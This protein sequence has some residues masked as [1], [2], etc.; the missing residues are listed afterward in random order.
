MNLFK[1]TKFFRKFGF[2]GFFCWVLYFQTLEATEIIGSAEVNENFVEIVDV[3]YRGSLLNSEETFFTQGANY[4]LSTEELQKFDYSDP[5][6]VLQSVPGVYIQEEDGFGLRPNIGM[7]GTSPHRSKKVTLM[8]DGVLITPAPYSSPAAYFFPNMMKIHSVEIFKGFSSVKFGPHTLGGAINFVTNPIPDEDESLQEI[9]VSLGRVKKYR[10]STGWGGKNWGY[11]LESYRMESDGFKSLPDGGDTGFEKNDIL[12]K[13]EYK[14]GTLQLFVKVAYAQEGSHETY[15]GLTEEDFK[16]SSYSRYAA[17][18][19]DFMEW[20]HYQYQMGYSTALGKE[21]QVRAVVYQH[22]FDRNWS[23][24]SGFKNKVPLSNYLDTQSRDFDPHFLRV[25]RGEYDSTLDN[26]EDHLILG[27]NNRRYQSRGGNF[28]FLY[29]FKYLG[30][31]HELSLGFLYHQDQI[32]RDHTW[33]EFQMVRGKLQSLDQG[34]NGVQN[35]DV[36]DAKSFFLEDSIDLTSDLTLSLGFR[37]EDIHMLRELKDKKPIEN[38]YQIFAPGLGIQYFP[39]E[40]WALLLGIN[41]GFSVLSPGQT[42]DVKPEE[43]LNYEV[44]LRYR[45]VFQWELMGF[46]NDYT[47]I[48]GLCSFS[49]GCREENIDTEFSGGPASIYGLETRIGGD[50]PILPL[51]FPVSLSYTK[52]MTKFLESHTSNYYEWG[53]GQIRRGDPLPYIPEDKLSLSLGVVWKNL[54]GFLSYSWQSSVYDQV[55]QEGR[56]MVGAYGVLDVV[57]KYKSSKNVEGFIRLENILD[58]NYIVSLRPY[59]ARPGKPQTL[60]LGFNYGFW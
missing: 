11:L 57:G 40:R 45:G 41:K 32:K 3:Y 9:N 27:N 17:S 50:L 26:G 34:G 24:L 58:K 56:R 29:P 20:D 23:K 38:S 4:T 43:S 12:F 36:A 25:L 6:R 60:S 53:L 14:R 7:R 28:R 48:K 8:E 16:K 49:S 19:N 22:G 46:Y 52:T 10:L 30:G 59:G 55:V 51:R 47:N 35:R 31:Y 21:G 44:G 15:L 37:W 42:E 33:N 2:I 18:A 13:G 39:W 54:S 5:H 1:G